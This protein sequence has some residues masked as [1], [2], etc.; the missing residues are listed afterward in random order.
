FLALAGLG[1]GVALGVPFASAGHASAGAGLALLRV[2]RFFVVDLFGYR[3]PDCTACGLLLGQ[4]VFYG[5]WLALLEQLL[6]NLHDGRLRGR[7]WR[8]LDLDRLGLNRRR[9]C[10]AVAADSRNLAL[11][12]RPL[13]GVPFRTPN[14]WYPAST[15]RGR[16]GSPWHIPLG[17]RR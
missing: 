8:L 14:Y 16:A 2:R 10:H 17:R 3:S 1:A 13:G 15:G 5:N 12:P 11:A 4:E 7:L 6:G 9:R